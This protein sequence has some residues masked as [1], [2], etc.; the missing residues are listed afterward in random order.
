MIDFLPTEDDYL[1]SNGYGQVSP[2]LV[3]L[4]DTAA[5]GEGQSGLVGIDAETSYGNTADFSFLSD[6]AQGFTNAQQL[7]EGG[8]SVVD[9][10]IQSLMSGGSAIG[11]WL[12]Q[13]GITRPEGTTDKLGRPQEGGLTNFGQALVLGMMK[14]YSDDQAAKTKNKYENDRL[15]RAQKWKTRDE[16]DA[17]GRTGALP[18]RQNRVGLVG[19]AGA[20]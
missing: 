7:A 9:N 6:P 3:E 10:M 1:A 2:D 11:G 12:D 14:G 16:A 18:V 20:Q 17:R 5:G 13:L 8:G 4:A 19:T 15:E